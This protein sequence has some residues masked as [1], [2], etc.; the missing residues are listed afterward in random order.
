MFGRL[1]PLMPVVFTSIYMWLQSEHLS[2]TTDYIGGNKPNWPKSE[3]ISQNVQEW[4]ILPFLSFEVVLPITTADLPV[5][6]AV[7]PE[8]ARSGL[9]T[10]DALTLPRAPRIFIIVPQLSAAIC[11]KSRLRFRS[12]LHIWGRLAHYPPLF[13][14]RRTMRRGRRL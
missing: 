13:R 11:G 12:A 1:L 2:A 8:G 10:I 3:A 14:Q 7:P 6:G 5:G 4:V 9:T